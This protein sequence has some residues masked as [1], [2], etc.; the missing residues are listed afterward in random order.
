MR[1]LEM[2]ATSDK[3]VARAHVND[4][5]MQAEV[6][7]RL[8]GAGAGLA[9]KVGRFVVLERIGEGGMGS[10]HRA[11]DPELDRQVALKVLAPRPT[12][13]SADDERLLRE[14][15]AMARLNHPNVVTVYEAGRSGDEV[16]VAMEL[17][18]GVDL[19]TW[20]RERS[21]RPRDASVEL[22]VVLGLLVQAGR[23]LAAAHEVGLVHRDFKPSNVLVGG[24]GRVRVA[25]F[26]LARSMVEASQSVEVDDLAGDDAERSFAVTRSGAVLGTPRYMA[27]EQR[28]G[29]A[30]D[31]KADQFAFCVTAWELLLGRHP[32][33]DDEEPTEEPPRAPEGAPERIVEVLRRGLHADPGRRHES[34]A[35]LLA[36]LDPAPPAPRSRW[37]VVAGTVALSVVATI[38]LIAQRDEPGSPCDAE[39]GRVGTVWNAGRR[40]ELAAALRSSGASHAEATVRLVGERLDELATQWA[41]AARAACEARL[42]DPGTASGAS[43]AAPSCLDAR[44]AELDALVD[45]LARGD[46]DVARRA[47]DAV[48]QLGGVELCAD[49]RYLA[50]TTPPREA[51]RAERVAGLRERLAHASAYDDAGRLAEAEALAAELLPEIREL[52]HPPLTVDVLLMLGRLRY[53]VG[54]RRVA[55]ATLEE[56]FESATALGYEHGAYVAASRLMFLEAVM[57]GHTDVGAT[58]ERVAVALHARI[59]DGDPAKLARLLEIRG[60]LARARG[61]LSEGE[62]RLEEALAA[63][64]AMEHP[65][66]QRLSTVLNERGNLA[67]VRGDYE[68][69]TR[70]YEEAAR[71]FERSHGPEHPATATALYNLGVAHY[72]RSAFAL[73]EDEFQRALRLRRAAFGGAGPE[74]SASLTALANLYDEQ[75][76]H[77]RALPFALEAV[78]LLRRSGS[79]MDLANALS[80][81]SLVHGGLGRED[82]ALQAAE[83]ALRIREEHARPDS[84]ELGESLIN[85]A[86][87]YSTRGEHARA[88]EVA[89]RGVAIFEALGDEHPELGAALVALASVQR[90]AG[91]GA[92][93]QQSYE[94]G[95]SILPPDHPERAGHPGATLGR[96]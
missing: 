66:L 60:S 81:L 44:L 9:V 35:A 62:A 57:L 71:S 78:E 56:A 73:A 6:A 27:P 68:E 24:D 80:N 69:A 21:S 70:R 64:R 37:L 45:V 26:G 61:E 23:G 12:L 75:G 1:R 14:A 15:S 34:M 94:R 84:P 48:W 93:A 22:E 52:D 30:V 53:R 17:V 25:D 49:P 28:A 3:A 33:P 67:M 31:D 95:L 40:D 91:H 65:P 38:G 42:H 41:G 92:E 5:L 47:V 82:A 46:D 85:L 36:A 90:R 77:E 10:V 59:D 2:E 39:A 51:E 63:L 50:A 74:V 18:D 88:L 89:Q 76:Q 16:F 55:G 11:Y 72:H 20:V 43:S 13:S 29:T 83:E 4:R 58:W 96:P 19:R 8:F 32:W 79:S 86:T 54:D 7:R 87:M